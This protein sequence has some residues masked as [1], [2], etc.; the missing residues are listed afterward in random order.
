MKPKHECCITDGDCSGPCDLCRHHKCHRAPDCCITAS[1]CKG[2]CQQCVA[3]KCEQIPNSCTKYSDCS[4]TEFCQNC[5]CV[6]KPCE[7]QI[8]CPP[9]SKCCIVNGIKICQ[10]RQCCVHDKDCIRNGTLP[11]YCDEGA[12][13]TGCER[14]FQCHTYSKCHICDKVL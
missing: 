5:K 12:C 11:L 8:E 10:G 6:E 9:C 1:D 13:S 4:S 2:D 3:N 14:N 7:H